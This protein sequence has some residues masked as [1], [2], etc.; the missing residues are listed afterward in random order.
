MRVSI[1]S[2]ERTDT[3]DA[4]VAALRDKGFELQVYGP[5]RKSVV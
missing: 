1:G 2:D 3:T 5:D 4:V